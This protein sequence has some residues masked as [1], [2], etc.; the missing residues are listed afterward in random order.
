[1]ADYVLYTSE[2]IPRPQR[3]LHRSI[4][5]FLVILAGIGV[6]ELLYQFTIAPKLLVESVIIKSDAPIP[7]GEI[8]RISQLQGPV[9]Y[10]KVHTLTLK[11]KLETVSWVRS[12]KVEK[13]F[14]NKVMITL[15]TRKPIGIALMETDVS[16]QLFAFDED[17]NLFIP[18]EGEWDASLPVFTGIRIEGA[19]EGVKFPFVLAR[20]IR[21]IVET[22]LEES[23]ILNCFSEFRIIKK[24]EDAY[25]LIAY[26]IKYPVPVRMGQQFSTE[27][28]KSALMV[29]DVMQKEHLLDKVEEIDFRTGNIL[30]RMRGGTIA[31][32]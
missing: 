30:Y 5:V 11:K 17:L 9:P 15:E 27:T 10:H 25:E 23:G 4:R 3:K 1:M 21:T 18:Q 14:P 28:F 22:R 24:G 16:T 19:T 32:R 8:L 2:S 29:L 26:P 6:G 31:G 7:K 12:A 20:M 13:V